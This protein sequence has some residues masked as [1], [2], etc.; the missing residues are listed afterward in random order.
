MY[1]DWDT[2]KSMHTSRNMYT[3]TPKYTYTIML[4]DLGSNSP[5]LERYRILVYDHLASKLV[6]ACI[7]V[8]RWTSLSTEFCHT[9]Q[10]HGLFRC[11]TKQLKKIEKIFALS[12][13]HVDGK[14][15]TEFQWKWKHGA[16]SK[17]WIF[18]SKNYTFLTDDV[19]WCT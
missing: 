18:T 10:E 12:L 2:L 9:T 11:V 1:N 16:G 17:C 8:A 14:R 13:V 7:W 4:I 6:D 5:R 19:K 15:C 3:Y